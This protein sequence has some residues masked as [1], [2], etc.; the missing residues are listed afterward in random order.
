MS[1]SHSFRGG[2]L[3]HVDHL[4]VP[5]AAT[6]TV[7]A[8][9]LDALGVWGDGTPGADPRATDFLVVG[10]ITLV[11]AVVVF[12]LLLPQMMHRRGAGAVALALGVLALVTLP[13]FWLGVTGVLGVG[14]VLLGLQHRHDDER[15]S[16][17][18]AGAVAGGVAAAAY[19][20]LYLVD[21][22]STNNVW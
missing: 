19:V 8:L 4:L 14:A 2:H 3:G 22:A 9:V 10:A 13:A 17:A 16:L 12:G 18:K 21:W 6:A 15:A 5:V 7:I 1:Y 20:V 11:F